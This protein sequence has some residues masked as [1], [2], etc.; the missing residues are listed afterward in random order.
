MFKKCFHCE[1]PVLSDKD[2]IVEK[3]NIIYFMCCPGCMAVF[4]FIVESGFWQYY[5]NR[6]SSGNKID[7]MSYFDSLKIFDDEK[8]VNKF[9]HLNEKNLNVVNL[10]V[11]GITCSACTWLIEKHLTNLNDIKRVYV[12]IAT[13][14]VIVVWD[15]KKLSLGSLLLEF[16]K[17]GYNA[18]PYN[19]K[20]QEKTNKAEYKVSLKNL[21][22]SGLGMSQTMMLSFALY[23]GEFN[24]MRFEYWCFIRWVLLV[25]TTPVLFFAGNKILL[26]AFRGLKNKN[27]GM[28][29]TVSI[30]LILAYI[31]SVINLLLNA[32]HVYFDSVTMFIFFLL[33]ARF[34]EM[35]TRHKAIDLVYSLQNLTTGLARLI[36]NGSER[37]VPVEDLDI[38]SVIL[39]K[40]GEI[41]P[42]DGIILRGVSSVD[43]SMLTGE[44]KPINKV[45]ENNVFAGSINIEGNLFVKITHTI[46]ESKV[47]FIIKLLEN[48]M[49]FKNFDSGYVNIISRYFVLSV[50]CLTFIVS[51]FW[52]FNG[53][54]NI[55]N[56]VLSMLVITCPCA[57]S[58]SVP[59]AVTASTNALSRLGFVV[60][61]ENVFNLMSNLT[62]VV[63]DKTGT[64][65]V[66]K[67]F[68]TN[69]HLFKN[70]SVKYLLSLVLLIE[71]KSNHPVS[72]AFNNFDNEYKYYF[73][74]KSGIFTHYINS[75]LE[76]S[77]NGKTYRIGS[78]SFT[79]Q[80]VG[81]FDFVIEHDLVIFIS[82]KFGP[83]GSF[84]LVNPLRN[85]V[86][87]SISKL[88]TLNIQIHILT[89]DPSRQVVKIADKLKLKNF[90]N[91]C[92][93]EDK[94]MYISDL[95]K[96][97]GTVMMVGDGIN[98]APALG[99]SDIS[100][101][102][103]SGSDI[104]KINSDIIL[105]N[106]NLLNIYKS[107]E[108]N[109]KT[110]YVIKENMFWAVLYNII[111]ITL[112]A[113]DVITPYYASIGMSLSSLVVVLN[114]LRLD[115]GPRV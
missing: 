83:V 68:I 91:N 25:I 72:K 64:L 107:I 33:V 57:L 60:L 55:I 6:E 109:K 95:Q 13:A 45:I 113:F 18:H 59:V 22:V 39:V 51:L 79:K 73:Y 16:R 104:T 70:V 100:V 47:Y 24:D 11:D 15:I 112:A 14:R 76:Y 38:N 53:H 29:F 31:Y 88:K 3:D 43:E 58:L 63:F 54:D 1:L 61:K 56:I 2:Y 9:V 74:N 41:I 26:S 99:Q 46:E 10:S 93:V 115:K 8:I 87:L 28:D 106:N 96:L 37:F 20:D 52:F 42:A 48:V 19:L 17:I 7:E 105:L 89:G 75:G 114:S 111:G 103:G 44:F 50:L 81:F 23:I 101:A 71:S 21:I 82:D 108:H 77:I 27:F 34:L 5:Q 40:A 30:S 86:M 69:I 98:D 80:L 4:K 67:Y 90:K 36:L 110:K 84:K 92:S 49:S 35:R 102:M 97:G 66:N 85:N 32:G 62:D 12:N 65:T 94:L 78:L